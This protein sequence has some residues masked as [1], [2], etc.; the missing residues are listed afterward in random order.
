MN[1]SLMEISE[2]TPTLDRFRLIEDI[3]LV[4]RAELDR[5]TISFRDLI[6]LDV[7]SLLPLTRPTGENIDLYAGEVLMGSGEILV[8]DSTMAVRIAVLR[9]RLPSSTWG[10]Q[11][12]EP[13]ADGGEKAAGEAEGNNGSR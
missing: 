13:R 9:D 7:D 1:N 2:E 4:L 12:V 5:T 6:R 11:P 3:P 10:D 8:I